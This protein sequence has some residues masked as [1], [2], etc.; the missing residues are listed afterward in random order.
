MRRL[1]TLGMIAALALFATAAVATATPPKTA[2]LTFDMQVTGDGVASGTWSA[3]SALAALEGK[4]GTVT[5]TFR[6]T[7]K[8]KGKG[9]K[10]GQIVHGHK[11]VTTS[12]GNTF[13]LYFRGHMKPTSA[14]TGQVNGRF[15]LKKG[16]GEFEGL[17]GTGK[18]SA[19]LNFQTGEL[20]A[21]YTVKVHQHG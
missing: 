20:D 1:F 9:A 15:V 7:G 5:Q 8:G 21:T 6:I 19:T 16:T 13:H 4:T 14:T 10:A 17:K 18:I 11:T 2:T 12:A 3:T